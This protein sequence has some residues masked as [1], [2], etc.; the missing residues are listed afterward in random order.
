MPI[1]SSLSPERSTPNMPTLT[2][3]V[4]TITLL[5]SPLVPIPTNVSPESSKSEIHHHALTGPVYIIKLLPS[6]PAPFESSVTVERLDF[7][8]THY[9]GK[10]VFAKLVP[11]TA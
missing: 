11:A 10:C 8:F 9:D 5:P 1:N 3:L 7:T 6:T 4:Y 2:G